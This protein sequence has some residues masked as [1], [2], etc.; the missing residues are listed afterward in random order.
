MT[1]EQFLD[2]IGVRAP[3]AEKKVAPLEKGWRP[4]YR[5]EEPPF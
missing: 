1:L 2:W 4:S 5:G 3:V